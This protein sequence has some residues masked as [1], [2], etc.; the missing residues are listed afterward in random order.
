[1]AMVLG[2]PCWG[3]MTMS[4]KRITIF[5]L[6]ILFFLS[7][8]G[9]IE[10]Q[11]GLVPNSVQDPST[12]IPGSPEGEEKGLP[13]MPDATPTAEFPLPDLQTSGLFLSGN[14]VIQGSVDTQG[15][16]LAVRN[17]TQTAYLQKR[18]WI[19]K[20]R[21]DVYSFFKTP[22]SPTPH[23]L[24][25]KAHAMNVEL[26]LCFLDDAAITIV[27]V[28]EEGHIDPQ[29]IHDFARDEQ[30]ELF[31]F[32]EKDCE[33]ASEPTLE[34][35]LKNVVYT[36]SDAEGESSLSTDGE[37]HIVQ[38]AKD[39]EQTKLTRLKMNQIIL[40]MTLVILIRVMSC[41]VLI[42]L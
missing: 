16:A 5:H 29:L 30:Y 19:Q 14:G 21:D 35:V 40:K 33:M 7:T 22:K 17:V 6:I 13:G 37:G 38:I 24:I 34:P 1:M 12:R 20:I 25:P 31:L 27:N 8:T 36:A 28:N 41:R 9:C 11:G 15:E 18:N 26:G 23:W 32:D 3:V 10:P 2:G 4:L 39:G 42:M